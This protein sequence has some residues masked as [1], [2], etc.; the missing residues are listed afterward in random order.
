MDFGSIIFFAP[1]LLTERELGDVNV[2]D[3]PGFAAIT[4]RHVAGD[5]LALAHGLIVVRV[6][7]VEGDDSVNPLMSAHGTAVV[8]SALNSATPSHSVTVVGAEG[9]D[10]LVVDRDVL[11]VVAS[12]VIELVYS[13]VRC[14]LVDQIVRYSQC[15]VILS[16]SVA[17]VAS[18]WTGI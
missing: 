3:L 1:R 18:V 10:L 7:G 13:C 17:S 4:G 16:P 8:R 15:M 5:S 6:G 11:G 2:G 9:C 12:G 14:G